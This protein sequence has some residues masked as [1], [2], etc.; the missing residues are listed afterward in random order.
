MDST[1]I[2]VATIA[3]ILSALFSGLEIAFTTSNRLLIAADSG[4]SRTMRYIADLFRRSPSNFL[5]SVLIGNTLSLVVLSLMLTKLLYSGYQGNIA[6]EF[7]VLATIVVVFGEFFP[8]VIVSSSADFFL[9]LF[10]LPAF[11]FYLLFYPI[12]WFCAYVSTAILWLFGVRVRAGVLQRR[13]DIADL[14]TLVE[15]EIASDTPLDNE[16]RMMQNALDFGDVKVRECMVPRVE[17]EA[18]DVDGSL[19]ELRKLFIATKFSRIPIY[20][21]T[22]DTVI[23]YASSRQLFDSPSSIEEMLREPLYV[24]SSAS[25][26]SLLEEFIKLQRSMAIVIDEFGATAGL[27]TTEDILEEI[28]GEID[29]EHDADYFVGKVISGGEYLLSGRAS[30]EELSEEFAIEIERS[31]DYETLAGFILYTLGDMP[32]VG[33]SFIVEGLGITIDRISS[34][35]ISLVRVKVLEEKPLP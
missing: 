12:I 9:K 23:G 27:V 13:F 22:I 8:R 2:V 17:I 25:A 33:D 31:E 19:D 5:A 7:I 26:K 21:G 24:P 20:R 10:A 6:V 16:M 29:D 18:F 35:R 1:A 14:Q 32:E 30:I 4:G 3:L 28:F 34:Q 11:I 15:E